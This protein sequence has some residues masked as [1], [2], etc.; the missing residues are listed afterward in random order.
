MKIAFVIGLPIPYPGAAWVRIESFVKSSVKR[1]HSVLVIC[2][3]K[4]MKSPYLIGTPFRRRGL[5]NIFSFFITTLTNI[6]RHR[7]DVVVIS[8]PPGIHAFGAS[9]ACYILRKKIVFDY[10]DQWE[11]YLISKTTNKVKRVLYKILKA[12]MTILYSKATLVVTVT[13]P[14]MEYLSKRGVENVHLI[15]N[16]ADTSLFKPVCN[17][18]SL[19]SKYGFENDEFI[20]VYSGYIGRYYRLD[21]C[22]KAF[23]RF[24]EANYF[25]KTKLLL[26]GEGEDLEK[27]LELSKVLK[28]EENVRYMG[29][30]YDKKEIVELIALADVGLIPYDKNPLW[31]NS[32]PAK[33]FE[34][35]SCGIPV[36][37]TVDSKSILAK[38]IDRE[39]IG[40]HVEPED[41]EKLADAINIL[42]SDKYFLEEAS[43]RARKLIERDFDRVKISQ[44]FLNLIEKLSFSFH[45]KPNHN[46]TSKSLK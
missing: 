29:V 42:S 1:G 6:L 19:R 5:L 17:K 31:R 27:I 3:E 40:I 12:L 21:T 4:R 25:K 18:V 15:P 2:T 36:I 10:R 39:K 22:V 33:F 14:F 26:M 24:I 23:A 32:L 44:N 20:L 8:V 35:A 13:P 43:K 28:I 45:E 9:I 46:L 37:A 34:Y 38:V 7:I 11:E 16:G 30:K 41:V